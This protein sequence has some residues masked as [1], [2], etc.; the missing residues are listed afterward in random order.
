MSNDRPP[1]PANTPALPEEPG[2]PLGPETM[3]ARAAVDAVALADPDDPATLVFNPDDEGAPPLVVSEVEPAPVLLP[4][5]AG[6]EVPPSGRVMA[7]APMGPAPASAERMERELGAALR[8]SRFDPAAL[9][10]PK[11]L[12]ATLGAVLGEDGGDPK[13]IAAR[14][15]SRY[16]EG[17]VRSRR[18]DR[19]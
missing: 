16:L 9:P 13:E 1:A 12:L 15:V 10:P 11:E 14:V 4:Q 2:A 3:I 8:G 6:L 19:G 18:R 17:T 5:P 7:T